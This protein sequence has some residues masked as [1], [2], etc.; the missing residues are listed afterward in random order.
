ML[1]LLIP[2]RCAVCD[3]VGRPLCPGCATALPPA[4]DLQ[5][6]DGLDACSALLAY[7]GPTRRLLAALKY[8]NHRDA[9]DA[10]SGALAL[11]LRGLGPGPGPAGVTW[12][13]T[14][15]RRRRHRGYDQAEL[16][17]RRT[18]AKAGLPASRLLVRLPGP[19]QTGRDRLH[20][21]AGPT[22]RAVGH[23]AATVVVM[24]DVWTTGATLSAAA[25]ALRE[26][27]ATSVL[28]LVLAVRP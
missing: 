12:A 1:D 15:P 9:M 6:P 11:L 26:A 27:G 25:G 23:P 10:V 13:P 2:P 17:A 4:P 18:A 24:D 3:A 21:L 22:F 7:D 8:R 19:A 28:G 14:S 5:P 20:R 16:L